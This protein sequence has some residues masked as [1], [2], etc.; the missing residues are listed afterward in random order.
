MR[1]ISDYEH[2]FEKICPPSFR[3]QEGSRR[4]YFLKRGATQS[5]GRSNSITAEQ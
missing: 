4:F 1:K 3:T 5:D 2:V